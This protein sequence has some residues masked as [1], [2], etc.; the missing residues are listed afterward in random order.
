MPWNGAGG[1]S[2]AMASRKRCSN[3]SAV[4]TARPLTP[5]RPTALAP[6][7]GPRNSSAQYRIVRSGNLV[8]SNNVPVVTEKIAWQCLHCQLGL[9]GSSQ[10]LEG[11]R[12]E[13]RRR[14]RG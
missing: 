9:V 14:R 12:L 1:W 7:P 5:D 8:Q 3:S 4:E 11:R 6:L 2:A 10:L 13:R